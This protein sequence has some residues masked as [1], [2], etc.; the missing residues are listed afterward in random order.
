MSWWQLKNIMAQWTLLVPSPILQKYPKGL[1]VDNAQESWRNS[2][3]P[4]RVG[5]SNFFWVSDYSLLPWNF[6]PDVSLLLSWTFTQLINGFESKLKT[7]GKH[8][9]LSYLNSSTLLFAK[10]MA[11]GK[12]ASLPSPISFVREIVFSYIY[13]KDQGGIPPF[14]LWICHYLYKD[15]GCFSS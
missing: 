13:A 14:L 3:W 7:N 10:L 11:N 8:A 6:L 4:H 9:N 1:L 2:R 12:H 5:P 15:G